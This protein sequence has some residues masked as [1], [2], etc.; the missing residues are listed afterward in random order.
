MILLGINGCTGR[1]GQLICL[2]VL[3]Q[4]SIAVTDAF[5]YAEHPLQ[6]EDLGLAIGIE[7]WGINV[8]KLDI[9]QTGKMSVL[10]DFSTPEGFRNALKYAKKHKIKLISGTTGLSADDMR[11]MKTASAAIP[12]V[13]STNMSTGINSLLVSLESMKE[14]LSD[15]NRNIEIIEYHHKLKKDAPSGTALSIAA[16]IASLTGRHIDSESKTDFPRNDDICIHSVRAGDIAGIHSIIISGMGETIEIKHT[17]HSRDTFASGVLKA[18]NF[19][20]AKKKGLYSMQDVI[21]E[22]Q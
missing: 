13:Y 8:R 17:A 18:V 4:D 22:N 14:L 7:P 12:I 1:M 19:I 10:V 9:K 6:N 20:H 3:A 2:H 16:K 11:K 15:R 21:R 5:E